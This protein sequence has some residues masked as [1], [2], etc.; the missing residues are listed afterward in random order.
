M[1][2]REI[3]YA[4][5]EH[6]PQTPRI[7]FDF[8]EPRQNDFCWGGLGPSLRPSPVRWTEEEIDYY[9]KMADS[10][11]E[12]RREDRGRIA[13]PVV[14]E[15][16]DLETFEVPDWDDPRR[17]EGLKKHFDAH[18]DLFRIVHFPGW[19]F[20]TGAYLR[21]R[22]LYLLDLV[23]CREE[24]ERLHEGL[25]DL[26]E[27]CIRNLA[28]VGADAFL[29]YEDLGFQDRPLLSPTMWREIFAKHYRRLCLAAHKEG[30]KVFMHSCGYL[31]P[32]LDDLIDV[33]IDC[34]QFDQLALYDMPAL[35]EKMKARKV[36][37]YAPLDIQKFL[38]SGDENL[39]RSE[40]RRMVQLFDK[41]LIVKSYPDLPGIGVRPEWDAWAY[42]EF[43]KHAGLESP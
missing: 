40:A 7:A 11:R 43:L 15:W 19:I 23:E 1:T 36:A 37:L 9:A 2:S 21:T 32:I 25:A 33:G 41:F 29:F 4:N 24:I 34:F 35:A 16:S 20:S 18:P 30:M 39:I 12:D 6:R 22:E 27:G 31:W 26:L 8:S 3:V 10:S 17:C 13:N 14:K 38:P 5:L 42:E 28:K